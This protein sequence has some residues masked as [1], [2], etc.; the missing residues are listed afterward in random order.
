MILFTEGYS[1]VKSDQ[2]VV[3]MDYQRNGVGKL[4]Y[5]IYDDTPKL[6]SPSAEPI[7][8]HPTINYYDIRTS[9]NGDDCSPNLF[10]FAS[11]GQTTSVIVNY[12]DARPNDYGIQSLSKYIYDL[13]DVYYYRYDSES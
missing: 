4:A 3:E 5:T 10:S 6:S 9:Y 2:T 11:S 13:T 1:I 7:S 12:C 8:Y